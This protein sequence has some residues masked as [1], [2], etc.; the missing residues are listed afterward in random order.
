MGDVRCVGTGGLCEREAVYVEFCVDATAI[1]KGAQGVEV[2]EED[3]G[4]HQLRQSPLRV[5]LRVLLWLQQ[6]L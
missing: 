6:F 3:D 4:L 2:C 1:D 5:L